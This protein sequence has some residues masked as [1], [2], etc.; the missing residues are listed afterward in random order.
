MSHSWGTKHL[1]FLLMLLLC[2]CGKGR[3]INDELD[4]I[5]AMI[6]ENPTG[7][8]TA[9][10]SLY[11]AESEVFSSPQLQ[12]RH[13]L[14][15]TYCKFKKFQEGTNDSLITIAEDYLLQHGSDYEKTLRLLF[16]GIMSYRN[17]SKRYETGF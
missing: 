5:H 9:L 14:L 2:S 1:I 15:D 12:A 8:Q 17:V 16:H 6:Q 3:R 13:I 7:A 4:R 10:D 11:Q